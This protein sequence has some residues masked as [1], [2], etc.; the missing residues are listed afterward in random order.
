MLEKLLN[1]GKH[2][3]TLTVFDLHGSIYTKQ[4]IDFDAINFPFICHSL[5]NWC[6]NQASAL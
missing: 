6:D 1:V 3:F 5:L 2:K 4:F